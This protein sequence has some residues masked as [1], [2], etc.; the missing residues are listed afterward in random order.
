MLGAADVEHR[1]VDADAAKLI[2]PGLSDTTKFAA[3]LYLPRDESGN[4]PL[5]TRQLKNIAQSVGVEFH[6]NS[7]VDSIETEHGRVAFQIDKRRFSADA[8]VISAG[9][10]SADLLKQI[11]I[12]IPVYPVKGYCA[13]AHIKNFERAPNGAVMDE[14]YKVAITRMGSRIRI[15]GTAELGST[16]PVLHE[17]AL[18]TLIKVG[19]DWFP[20][21]ANFHNSTFWCGARPM[22]P[23]GAPLLGATPLKNVFINI[24]DGSSDWTMAAGSGRIVAD[25][26]SGRVPEIDTDG[27]TLAR[28]G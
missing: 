18:R 12:R 23:D 7:R 15:A 1:L 26:V 28:Y 16:T 25:L 13:T 11:G 2:E 20:D 27:L 19:E 10:D 17:R 21:A 22:L 24:G 4:C 9:T 5:F 6:F 14:S 8:V 3:A